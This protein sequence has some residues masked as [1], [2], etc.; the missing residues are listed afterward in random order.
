MRLRLPRPDLRWALI[1]AV[2]GCAEAEGAPGQ[3]PAERPPAPE[4]PAAPA[5]PPPPSA[6]SRPPL[7]PLAGDW[8]ERIELPGGQVV[9]VA[10]PVGARTP[11]PILVAVHG[12]GDRPDWACGGWRLGTEAYAFV[13]CPQ[14]F[15]MSAMTFGW[16][17]DRAILRAID[18]ALPAVR[19]RYRAHVADVP[20]VYAGF[21]QGAQLAAFTLLSRAA[22]LPR[23]VFAEGGY[24]TTV[25]AAFA[26]KYH[27]AGG[28]RAL[29]LCGTPNCFKHSRRAAH[30]L[31]AAGVTTSAAGDAR[32]G[33]NLNEP[34]QRALRQIWPSFVA[35]APGWEG[36]GSRSTP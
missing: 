17:N 8:L 20:V 13:V 2:L 12:A 32:S 25:D 28:Q 1:A 15:P 3:L 29:L 21:S 11:R 19:Q 4:S 22:E 24:E 33:H 7:A 27:A 14:G 16:Q 35:G 18:A 23:V 6:A 10:P 34:M 31:E 36:Y 30:V 5:L 26:R 9:F